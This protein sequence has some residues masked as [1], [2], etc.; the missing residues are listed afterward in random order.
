MT[1]QTEDVI[2]QDIRRELI[3]CKKT[4]K[5]GINLDINEYNYVREKI[6][7]LKEDDSI[8]IE[9]LSSS[10]KLSEQ[11]KTLLETFRSTTELGRQRI[12]QSTLNIY[13]D[14]E[15]KNTSTNTRNSG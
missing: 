6:I 5:K 13:D 12:I 10:Y 2:F 14:L 9:V 4:A 3:N 15:K 1:E 11:E 8:A 7:N